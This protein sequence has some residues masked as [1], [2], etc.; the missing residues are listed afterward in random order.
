MH[1]GLYDG[2]Q[3]PDRDP[4]GASPRPIATQYRYCTAI[5]GRLLPFRSAP[6]LMA[7]PCR[8]RDGRRNM[9]MIQ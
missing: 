1:P 8:D 2:G 4:R 5:L 6:L 9:Q 3:R 7:E